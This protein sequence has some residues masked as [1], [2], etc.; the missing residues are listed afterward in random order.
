M[1]HKKTDRFWTVFGH[2]FRGKVLGRLKWQARGF[3]A[4]CAMQQ[5]VRGLTSA[6]TR[7]VDDFSSKAHGNWP[8]GTVL[9]FSAPFCTFLHPLWAR[10][11]GKGRSVTSNR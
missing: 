2:F 3:G 8:D 1:E 9:H 4:E 11:P 5:I 10:A 7:L 6:A